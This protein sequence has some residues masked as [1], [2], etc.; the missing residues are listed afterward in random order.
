MCVCVCVGLYLYLEAFW[1]VWL[2]S[3]YA[4]DRMSTYD[5]N[6]TQPTVSILCT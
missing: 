3:V 2:N 4:Y 6:Q 5:E 1:K